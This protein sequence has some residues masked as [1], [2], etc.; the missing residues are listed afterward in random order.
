MTIGSWT[1]RPIHLAQ[2]LG[3]AALFGLLAFLGLSFTRGEDRIA[4]I[5]AANAVVLSVLLRRDRKEDILYFPAV[6]V[7]NVAANLIIGDPI[8]RALGLSLANLV[9]M[10][11][12]WRCMVFAGAVPFSP[13]SNRDL[14]SFGGAVLMGSVASGLVALLVMWPTGVAEAAML[15]WEWVRADA[16]S[17]VLVVPSITILFQVWRD[18]SHVNQKQVIETAL[19]L[20][21]GTL[22]ST[23]VFWQTSYPFLFLDALVVLFYV[24]R[25]GAPGAAIGILNIAIIASVATSLGHGPIHLVQGGLSEKLLVLQIFLASSF[26]MGL[27]VAAI[28]VAKR[29]VEDELRRNR[30]IGSS[31]ME[32]TRQVIFRADRDNRWIYVNPAWENVSG[33]AP[34]DCVGGCL[35]DSVYPED[36]SEVEQKVEQ[37]QQGVERN[38]TMRIRLLHEDC[39]IRYVEVGLTG[40][41]EDGQYLGFVGSM[42]DLTSERRSRIALEQSEERFR[43]LSDSAPLGICRI[44]ALGNLSYCNDFFAALLKLNKEQLRGGAWKRR[45]DS[46]QSW[47]PDDEWSGIGG[48]DKPFRWNVNFSL[49]DGSHLKT[50]LA[51]VKELDEQGAISGIICVLRDITRE[52]AA[53][54]AIHDAKRTLETLANLSPGGIFRTT[55]DGSLTYVNPAWCKL[56]SMSLEDAMDGGWSKAIHPDDRDRVWEEWHAAVK[57][58]RVFRTDF[59]FLRANGEVAWVDAL[60]APELNEKDEIVG[61]VGV[62]IDISDR[63][64]LEHELTQA[65]KVAEGAARAKANFL[66]NMSH[67]IRT[68]MNGVLGFTDLLLNSDLDD[69]QRKYAQLVAE[70]GHAMMQLLNDILDISKIEAGRVVIASQPTDIRH[71][72]GSCCKLMNAEADKKGLELTL[73][74]DDAV[75]Q[76]ILSDSLR[77]RQIILNLVGNALKFTAEGYITIRAQLVLGGEKQRDIAISVEDTGLGISSTRMDAIF[78]PFE[79]AD[80]STERKYGG[81]G[82][83]LPISLQLAEMMGGSLVVHSEEGQGSTFTLSLPLEVSD[84]GDVEVRR[85]ALPDVPLDFVAE[86]QGHILLVEDH[87]INQQLIMAM[88]KQLGYTVELAPDGAVALE[89][90]GQAPDA[91][92][93]FDLVLMDIQMPNVDGLRA[94]RILRAGGLT[95]AELPIIALTANAFREDIIIS[96]KAGMQDHLSKPVSSEA[97]ARMLHKWIGPQKHAEVPVFAEGSEELPPALKEQYRERRAIVLSKVNNLMQSDFLSDEATADL[98]DQLHKLAGTAGLFGE[99]ELGEQAREL[100]SELRR[101]SEDERLDVF[102][103]RAEAMLGAA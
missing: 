14:L 29:R 98:V 97:L 7:A 94:T 61:F 99:Y 86:G 15:W 54:Q 96:H 46:S 84:N 77:L 55:G 31:I 100:E 78:R 56:A 32:N 52:E 30:D 41:Y 64:L 40:L 39:T 23:Y 4:A 33:L 79:Q 69:E 43:R 3:M 11:L 27:P 83:G 75:P 59:R 74:V 22:V 5:W 58:K 66:A 71:L 87:D 25:L 95:P 19:I 68:P 72:L 73:E 62:N 16:L 82:L 85:H 21:I 91:S 1:I 24:F 60:A 38:I 2:I 18:R 57:I 92:E 93:R 12:V 103:N 10:L 35:M 34:K 80:D 65:K 102:R 17:L 28:L 63:K 42:Y 67:E 81:T 101:S 50:S 20:L 49:P 45:I 13:S 76:V 37:I 48:E 88:L 26:M 53:K 8:V 36:L 9:E 51:A 44:D 47:P 6:Y 70:S 90:L 89:I